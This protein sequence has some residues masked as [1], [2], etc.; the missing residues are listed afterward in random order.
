MTSKKVVPLPDLKMNNS[1]SQLTGVQDI[2]KLNTST[3][4]QQPE[5]VQRKQRRPSKDDNLCSRQFTRFDLFGSEYRWNVEG[6]EL[7]R[8]SCG[9][10]FS[11][12]LIAC[13]VIF[14]MYVFR[15]A[16]E[17]KSL[18]VIREQ[19]ISNYFETDLEIKQKQDKFFFAV[20]VSSMTGFETNQT[21]SDA[22]F[23]ELRL[24]LD[25]KITGGPENG[26]I[27]DIGFRNCT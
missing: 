8:T 7:Y 17:I 5:V 24:R 20:G 3:I 2:S 27:F 16:I 14:S 4:E 6:D 13:T 11:L 10:L 23:S 15:R 22:V 19:T 26:K 9:A 1:L 12:A 25:Y 18:Q 21:V